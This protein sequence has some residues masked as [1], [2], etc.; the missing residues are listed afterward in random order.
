[1][2]LEDAL[3]RLAEAVEKQNE[4]VGANTNTTAAAKPAAEENPKAKVKK[5][6]EAKGEKPKASAKPED[7]PDYLAMATALTKLVEVDRDAVVEVL[8]EYGV[9]RAT[10]APADKY[11][12]IAEKLNAKL[13]EAAAG[14]D[15][16]DGELI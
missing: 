13:E 6:E 8:G 1:M 12:E 14:E 15:D 7:N 2:S 3:N 5:K 10:D 11:A 16:D 9:K 4:I